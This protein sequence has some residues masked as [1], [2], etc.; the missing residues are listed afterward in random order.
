MGEG[1]LGGH[2]TVRGLLRGGL[3]RQHLS[4]GQQPTWILF[5]YLRVWAQAEAE[6]EVDSP[7]SREPNAGPWDHDLSRR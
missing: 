2:V 4:S 3:G 6:G 7:L 5:N 1:P